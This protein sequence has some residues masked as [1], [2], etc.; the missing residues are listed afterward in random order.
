MVQLIHGMLLTLAFHPF[1]IFIVI[2]I[3]LSGFLFYLER[4]C[5]AS[6]KDKLFKIGFKNGF[7][8][9]FG[10]FIT[11]LY[12]IAIPL[13]IDVKQYW[14]LIPFALF[15]VPIVLSS[16]YGAFSGLISTFLFIK[17][18]NQNIRNKR[19]GIA[20]L[21]GFGFFFAEILRS[22]LIVLFPWNLLGYASGY[23]LPL[24]Q[25]ASIVGVYGLSLLLFLLGT[26]PYTRNSIAISLMTLSVLIITMNGRSRLNKMDEDINGR[27]IASLY[28]IQPNFSSTNMTSGSSKV[29][30]EKVKAILNEIKTSNIN[31]NL[32]L[33]ILPESGIPL[34]I[35]TQQEF[36][37]HDIMSKQGKNSILISGIDRY[38][39]SSNQH[40][41]SMIAV[42][43]N[44]E[45]I[46]AYDKVT[47]APFGE[48]IPGFDSI[49]SIVSTNYG[50]TP[51]HRMKN[52]RLYNNISDDVLVVMPTICFEAILSPLINMKRNIA[53]LDLILNI[54]N[55][56]W[57]GNSLGPYQHLAMARMRAIEYGVPVVRVAKTGISAVFNSHGRLMRS[58]PLNT[59]AIMIVDMPEDKVSTVYMKII[60]L[61]KE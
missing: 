40:F 21:F 6:K 59:E 14:F 61:L 54:T 50:F 42:N 55:D 23:S 25:F 49:K 39:E 37:L 1:D 27:N 38:N 46:D 24:M 41:N 31:D 52:F 45:I 33:M 20:I 12:W 5:L 57:L 34:T 9:F 35:S 58:L 29:E 43:N 56:S 32:Q 11:S 10:H 60:K 18:N 53:D 47:L 36:I 28:I 15:G 44:S 2:P 17:I 16:F 48:Y 51:G 7:T 19:V 8:F 4:E 30:F 3:S 26:M 13:L 22:H